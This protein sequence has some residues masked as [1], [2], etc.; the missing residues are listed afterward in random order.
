MIR[1]RMAPL[2]TWV[3]LGLGLTAVALFGMGA[4]PVSDDVLL[5]VLALAVALFGLPHGALDPWVAKQAGIWRTASGLAA[6]HV[7]YVALAAAV[8]AVWWWAPA[9]SLALFLAI[10]AWHFAGDWRDAL[11]VASRAIAGLALLALPAWRWTA[12][13]SDLFVALSGP[14]GAWV[15]QGLA[16]LAPWL[17]AGTL[18]VVASVLPRSRRTALEL[19]AVGALALLLPPLVYFMVYFCAL[20]SLR[21]LRH[22]ARD[23]DAASRRR[24]AWVA[25]G[26]TGLTL[27]AAAFAWPW[28]ATATPAALP[29]AELL[30]LV[31]IGLAA[32]T[33]PHMLVVMRAEQAIGDRA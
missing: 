32:L 12:E 26:Y 11:P 2:E 20:H 10:S 19:L 13:V 1:A 9:T 18:A 22:S 4:S 24:M 5:A 17:A 16:Q 28:L 29:G 15:A 23:S 25:A 8:V 33:L 21:H 30:R 31:F 6:F 3:F 14:A 7:V 27:V